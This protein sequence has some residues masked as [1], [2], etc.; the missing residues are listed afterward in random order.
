[1][2][3]IPESVAQDSLYRQ[4]VPHLG[5]PIQG[6]VRDTYAIPGRPDLL[7]VVAS[8]RISIFDFVLG[9]TVPLKG[10]VLTAMTV[11]WLRRVLHDTPNHLLPGG[12]GRNL[13]DFLPP[14]VHSINELMTRGLVVRKLDMVPVECIVRGFLTGS[15]LQDYNRT[16]AVC[17]HVLPVGLGDGSQLETPIFTPSTK[18][19][20]GHD[21]NIDAAEVLAEYGEELGKRSLD[22]FIRGAEYA[23]QRRILLADTKFE[24]GRDAKGVLTLGDEVV[25]PDSSR[26]WLDSDWAAAVAKNKS[27]VGFDKQAVRDQGKNVLTPFYTKVGEPIIGVN[28]LDPKDSAH[29][30]YVGALVFGNTAVDVT[31]QTYLR[32]FEML[33]GCNLNRF[34]QDFMAVRKKD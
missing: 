12:F 25:T 31:T 8:D 6:K 10:A 22:L 3:Y 26:F 24:L 4:L 14:E 23:K 28:N 5:K 13:Y 11:M 9:F 15:G 27:P 18:A 30:D 17:G 29:R 7:L 34:Q 20:E 21:E 1:M 2:P 19:A 16:G 33:A 32:I